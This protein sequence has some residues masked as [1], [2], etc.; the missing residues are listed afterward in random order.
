MLGLERKKYTGDLKNGIPHGH[1]MCE[2]TN[3]DKYVGEFRGGK[4]E[5][6]G[7]LTFGESRSAARD[8]RSVV[9]ERPVISEFEKWM[10]AIFVED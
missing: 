6:C 2:F 8:S 4:F 9:G 3:G 10:A 5:G 7:M 1:G